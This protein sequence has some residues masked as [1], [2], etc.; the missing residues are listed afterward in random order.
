[1]GNYNPH[2][3]YILGQEW[4]PIRDEDTVFSPSVNAV[5]LGHR[6]LTTGARTL[7]T[8][9]F[10][11]NELRPAS[12]RGQTFMAAVYPAGTEDQSGPVSSVIIPVNAVVG[13]SATASGAATLVDCLLTQSTSSGIVLDC[14]QPNTGIAMS[15]AVSSSL[16][17]SGKRILGVNLLSG[18][19]ASD[20][21]TGP[22]RNVNTSRIVMQTNTT[23]GSA[24]DPQALFGALRLE[25]EIDRTTFGE[26]NQFWT[27]N[28][29]NLIADRVPWTYAQLTRLDAVATQLYTK[30][31][32]GTNRGTTSASTCYI[33]YAALEVIYCEETRVA[34]G[35]TQFGTTNASH[36]FGADSVLGANQIIM[37]DTTG[38]LNP[39]LSTNTLYDLVLSS[40][41]V[42]GLNNNLAQ[43]T[44]DYPDLNA[45]L[46]LYQIPPHPGV[47]VDIPFPLIDHIGD[48]F[49]AK[50]TSTLP[51]LSL[52]T[53]AGTMIEPH[54]YGRQV[55]AQVYGT[56]TATQGIFDTVNGVAAP[57][58]QVRYYARRFGDTTIPLTLTGVGSL[59]GSSASI[60]PADFDALAEILDGWRE[61]TLR[62]TLAP[63][64]GAVT[65]IPQFTW[66][67]SG[68]TSGNRW[69]VLGAS[70]PS[71]SGVPGNLYNRVP[72]PNQ[73]GPATYGG[74]GGFTPS[75]AYIA[76]GAAAHADNASVTPGLPAGISAARTAGNVVTLLILAAIRSSGTGTV[77]TPTGY[78]TLF[79]NGNF[80][81]MGKYWDGVEGA[82]TIT[83][84]NGA[85]GDT[86][87]AQMAAWTNVSLDVLNSASQL[88]GSAQ[89]I[90]Y[91]ALNVV[92]NALTLF[93]GWKQDDCTS[94]NLLGGLTDVATATTTV[95]NDQTIV[96]QQLISGPISLAS[97]N[98]TVIG[99]ASAISRG[100]LIAL[101][102]IDYSGEAIQLNWMPQGVASP[103]VT[104]PADDIASDAVLILSQDPPTVT[105][106][107]LTAQTQVVTG[108]GLDCGSLPCCIPS[109]IAYQRVTWSASTL[110]TTG[111]GAYE[112]QRLDTVD[113]TFNTIM[114]ATS[115]A[116]T[117]FNDFEARVGITSAYRIRAL[118]A[119]NFAGQWS[120]LVSGAPPTPGVTGGCSNT[121]GALIF[122]SN[123]D[124]SGHSNAAYIMNWANDPIEDFKLAEGDNMV[125]FQPMY[126]RDG[127]IAFHG[128]ERGLEAFD[129]S[130]LL[131]A[132]AIDPI[133]LA[134]ARTLR[135]LAWN[136]LPYVCV[137]DDIGDRWFAN[138][139][140]PAVNARLNR[141][142]YMA[143]VE[144]VETTST[145][146]PVNP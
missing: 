102:Q 103:Y 138:V 97:G 3:P 70:A 68:E 86:C 137:R 77:N 119:L 52:H 78:T 127:S 31:E 32:T 84:N 1:M 116:V 20:D 75:T 41:D 108:I 65:G 5:E 115:I 21:I 22:T 130:L 36:S 16:V 29:P 142:K 47:Q 38:A 105:G 34:Y 90:A 23:I 44:S 51:Q 4:V 25:S 12:D 101:R 125:S 133:R 121:T 67:A 14:S 56:N 91:P 104:A 9:R 18:T 87:S 100:S 26:I 58:P 132:T 60:T 37:H 53:S 146:Y 141:T 27:A 106:V 95:G 59:A 17:L 57:Y 93:T 126:G 98:F 140:V 13:T 128:T 55:A 118:N 7:A 82:P 6:F 15:F 72:V 99:G 111:F 19:A 81:L 94:I 79:T 96:W 63:A 114:L 120:S 50:A 39:V 8:A 109:G 43:L 71:I 139:R 145:P 134:D 143:R 45:C 122:T 76:V 30:I 2:A 123:A 54:V 64:L 131:Q 80:V 61:V 73:L 46:Q 69:E 10:Y 33:F 48:P 74:F 110:P 66:S 24:A 40:A 124:Q 144:I 92:D 117:G 28:S 113:G 89:N 112:L 85:A 83:F 42:G 136:A 129:R 62:F 35:A 88:N 11:I 107:T 49:V 135:D